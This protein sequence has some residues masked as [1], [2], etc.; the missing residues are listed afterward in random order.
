MHVPHEELYLLDNM[1]VL[2]DQ[3]FYGIRKGRRVIKMSRR[4][5]MPPGT[6][7][8]RRGMR[9][10]PGPEGNAEFGKNP[11]KPPTSWRPP[12]TRKMVGER[13]VGP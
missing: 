1:Q 6:V 8:F 11:A 13:C 5:D 4:G 7:I 9:F 10:S 3:L 12:L 2:A